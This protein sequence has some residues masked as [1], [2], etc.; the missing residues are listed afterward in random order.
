MIDHCYFI[1]LDKRI[2]RKKHIIENVMTFFNF[3]ESQ[4]SRFSA[5]DTS[6]ENCFAARSVGCALSHINVLKDAINK[7]YKHI[8]VL[9][10]DF[11]PIIDTKTLTTN[12][13]YFVNN[14]TDF[15]VCQLSY[16]NIITP[17]ACDESEIVYFCSNS[18]TASAYVINLQFASTIIKDLHVAVEHLMRGDDP[19]IF[20][21]DQYWKKYQ[22]IKNKWWQLKR[23]GQQLVD[24]SDLERRVV[25][26]KC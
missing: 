4:Y 20:A 5:I 22:T 9:E 26:Y 17:I 7:K 14:Y 25:D 16:K 18:Q 8:L 3:N 15:N 19:N 21:Y 24:Y 2:D 23:C 10:D 6:N 1:N 12:W 13:K 11:E